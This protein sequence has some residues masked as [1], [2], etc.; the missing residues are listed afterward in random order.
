MQS[1]SKVTNSILEGKDIR[2]SLYNFENKTLGEVLKDIHKQ[3]KEGRDYSWVKIYSRHSD[4]EDY[5]MYENDTV[6]DAYNDHPDWRDYEVIEVKWL[7]DD[8]KIYTK[9]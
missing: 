2:E 3:S 5:L 8:I 1:V 7:G 9:S 4:G 6:A